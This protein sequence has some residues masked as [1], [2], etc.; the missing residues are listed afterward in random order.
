MADRSKRLED[1]NKQLRK[2]L[3]DIRSAVDVQFDKFGQASKA[4]SAE[5]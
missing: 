1:E 2:L 3:S 4:A 5:E